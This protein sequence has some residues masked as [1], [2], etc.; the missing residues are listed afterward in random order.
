MKVSLF[1]QIHD[2]PR[3]VPA[4]INIGLLLILVSI[5][6]DLAPLCYVGSIFCLISGIFYSAL[7]YRLERKMKEKYKHECVKARQ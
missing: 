7:A 5:V 4:F 6:F 3:W 1:C 2:E